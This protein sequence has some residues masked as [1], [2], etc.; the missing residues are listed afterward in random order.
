[1]ARD[2]RVAHD[3]MVIFAGR[4]SA[5]P[6]ANCSVC[7]RVSGPYWWR[8]RAYRIEDPEF[9][10]LPRV[11]VYCQ[12]CADRKFGAPL[13]RPLVERRKVPRPHRPDLE[14]V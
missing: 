13:R 4:Q 1:M 5:H 6:L 2:D 10:D 14:E 12:S 3:Q 9:G 8:W 11:A 7:G